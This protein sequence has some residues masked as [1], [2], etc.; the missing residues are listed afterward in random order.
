MGARSK[1]KARHTEPGR[2]RRRRRGPDKNKIDDGKS[3]YCVEVQK[4]SRSDSDGRKG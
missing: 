3:A 2:R 1:A 4:W